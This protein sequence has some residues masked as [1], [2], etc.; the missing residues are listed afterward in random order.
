MR[1]AAMTAV[2][3][4]VA[5]LTGCGQDDEGAAG[6][7]PTIV[8]T[9]SVLGDVVSEVVGDAARVVTL[10]GPGVSPHE[11]ALSAR[12]AGEVHDADVIILN[13]GGFEEGVQDVIDQAADDGVPSLDVLMAI[14]PE[15]DEAHEPDD[16]HDDDEAD[17]AHEESENEAEDDHDHD[18]GGADPHFFTD[19]VHMAEAVVALG[20]FLTENLPELDHDA[21]ASRAEAYRD[22][23][24]AL[25]AEVEST[26]ADIP[27]ERRVLVTNHDVFGYFADR[28]RFEVIGAVI[29]TSTV[30]DAASAAQLSDLADLIEA[31]DV[32][33]IFV[34]SSSSPRLAETVA[35]EVG[36][37]EVVELFTESLGD[38]ASAASTYLEMVRTNA[39]RIA[40][41]LT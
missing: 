27:D 7:Q 21:V 23:L 36:G 40:A 17:D 30:A 9:T 37:V 6:D 26:L 24:R 22:Q 25:D 1:A 4:A 29:P 14:E 3:L 35:S 8:V 5:A 28:Y 31:R 11:F 16:G 32:P 33:A 15:A 20:D 41:A 34:D 13:G 2:A 18:D 19:P 12:Q 10:I 39:A 38:D